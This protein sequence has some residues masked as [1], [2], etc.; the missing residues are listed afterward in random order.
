MKTSVFFSMIAVAFVLN[1]NTAHAA[2]NTKKTAH[3]NH[4]TSYTTLFDVLYAGEEEIKEVAEWMFDPVAFESEFE[5]IDIEPWMVDVKLFEVRE[6][7]VEIEDWMLDVNS[8]ATTTGNTEESF[9]EIE[10]WMFK[11]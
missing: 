10:D 6:N 11:F 3:S 7:L 4:A 9:R 8:F 2:E 5:M 1:L